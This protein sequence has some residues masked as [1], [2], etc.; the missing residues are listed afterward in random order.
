MA[1]GRTDRGFAYFEFL[2]AYGQQCSLA[3][4][5]AID[6][7]SIHAFDYPGTSFVCLGVDYGLN[8]GNCARMHLSRD[9]VE[10]LIALLQQWLQTGEFNLS[11]DD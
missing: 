1:I 3:Q 4:S 10:G 2:D 6:E 8:D 7:Q 11:R 9:Q 5:P